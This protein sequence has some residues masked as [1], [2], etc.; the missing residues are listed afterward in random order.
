MLPQP[1]HPVVEGG[2]RRLQ[3]REL[4]V[5]AEE[6]EH[7][8]EEDGPQPGEGEAGEGLRVHDEGQA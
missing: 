8:E 6:E 4:R 7:E 1:W 5:Q 2:E 3:E